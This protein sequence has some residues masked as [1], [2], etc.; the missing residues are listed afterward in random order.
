MFNN[1]SAFLG[2]GKVTNNDLIKMSKMNVDKAQKEWAKYIVD[3][4][5]DINEFIKM[6]RN[7]FLDTMKPQFLP[8]FWESCKNET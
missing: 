4:C 6:W 5:E 3:K 2:K 1:I 7:H 8:E